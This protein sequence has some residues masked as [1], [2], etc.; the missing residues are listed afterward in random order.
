M[1]M[2]YGHQLQHAVYI[3]WLKIPGCSG[4]GST[5]VESWSWTTGI[6]I[7]KL[8]A[9]TRVSQKYESFIRFEFSYNKQFIQASYAWWALRE[10]TN[11]PRYLCPVERVLKYGK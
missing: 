4:V 5:A 10:G 1:R 8:E 11:R 9:L 7:A 6:S 3:I 2:G